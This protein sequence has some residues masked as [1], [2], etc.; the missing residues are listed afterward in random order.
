MTMA[1]SLYY[2]VLYIYIY[3]I[4]RAVV[5]VVNEKKA[6]TDDKRLIIFEKV[7]QTIGNFI[8]NFQ[9]IFKKINKNPLQ[10]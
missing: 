9:Y 10:A 4:Y 2:Y 5:A 3:I 7:K 6:M 8:F 1:T